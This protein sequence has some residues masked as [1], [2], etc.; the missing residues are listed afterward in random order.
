MGLSGDRE[1]HAEERAARRDRLDLEA[2]A[3]PGD[4]AVAHRET[5]AGALADGLGAEERLE[6]ALRDLGRHAAA[7]VANRHDGRAVAGE[8]RDPDVARAG[9]GIA[10]VADEMQE[11]L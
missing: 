2:T 6:D 3:V 7:V 1:G 8:G 9:D 5:E 11:H 4:D 10:G